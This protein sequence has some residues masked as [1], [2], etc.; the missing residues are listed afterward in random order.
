MS[1]DISVV[2]SDHSLLG[3]GPVWDAQLRRLL[4]LDVTRGLVYEL[5]LDGQNRVLAERDGA[6]GSVTPRA[7]GGMV[8]AV[9][10]DLITIDQDGQERVVASAEVDDPD[11][12]INDCRC[13][14]QGRLWA[15]TMTMSRSPGKCGLYRLEPGEPLRKILTDVSVSNGLG[16]SPEGDRMFYV[17]TLSSRV[18]VLD[19]DGRD[20]SVSGRRPF[21]T[22]DPADGLPDGL[23][24]DVEG[25]VWVCLFRGGAIHRYS[26]DGRL[27]TVVRLP[28][29]APTC[30]VFGGDDLKSLYV[31]TARHTLTDEQL[32]KDPLAGALLTLLP[33][34]AGVPLPPYIG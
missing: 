16:W 7:A 29:I 32:A 10:H 31:T 6:V 13:D 33:G 21:A 34:V 11:T 28:V 17:D 20:G 27:D 4:H 9:G 30:P 12:R 25:G 14:P 26:A 24:V 8:L 19:F 1:I 2:A 23:A 18:D 15:G 3:E 5:T 22:I